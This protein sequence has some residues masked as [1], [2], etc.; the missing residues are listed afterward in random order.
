[1][2]VYTTVNQQQLEDFLSQYSVGSLVEFS[3]IQAGIENS[4]YVIVTSQGKFVLTLFE[5][6]TTQQLTGYFSLLNHLGQQGFPSPRP[7][8]QNNDSFI[9]TINNKPAALFNHLSGSSVH[10]PSTEQCA[11]VGSYLAKLHI[12]TRHSHFQQANIKNLNG[13][14]SVFTKISP[15]LRKE[16]INLLRS[17][18]D[19]QLDLSLPQLPMGIIHADLFKD[20]VLIQ[21]VHISGILDFYNACTD[22]YIFDIAVTCNDWCTEAGGI[23]QLKFDALLNGYEKV[24]P[25]SVDEIDYLPI[26]LRR[27]ALRFW[28]SRIE[29]QL[30]PKP[31]ELTSVK[32]PLAFRQLLEYHRANAEVTI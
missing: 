30:N 32:D 28:L 15:Y 14:Q 16:E 22:Y 4:N 26:F 17:E 6:L 23:N 31:G 3:G 21:H 12:Y 20:N 18:F 1:M 2:S 9:T 13:C 27:A 8:L 29:H 24:R 5:S 10:K 11:E 25:L 7:Q 19:F